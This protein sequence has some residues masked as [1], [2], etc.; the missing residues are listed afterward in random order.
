MSLYG[1]WVMTGLSKNFMIADVRVTGL[2]REM[3]DFFVYW[4]L[5]SILS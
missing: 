2:E 4:L 1:L 3:K 5:C